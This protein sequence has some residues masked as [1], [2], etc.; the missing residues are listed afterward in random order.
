M[1]NFITG[2]SG[3]EHEHRAALAAVLG[4]EKAEFFFSRLIH[5][6]FTEA[7][8]AFFASV[9]FNC[10]RVPFNY[11]HFMD[12]DNP[13]VIKQSGFDVLDRIV[14][15]CAKH[16]IYVVLDL[17]AVPGGQNQDWHSDSGISRAL[18]WEFRDFQTRMIQ[19]WVAI[20]KHYAGN[21]VIAGYNPLNEPADPE[22][23]RLIEW[24]VRAEKAIREVD[25]EHIL[26]IDGNTYAMDFSHF[27][28]DKP[29]PNAVYSCHDYSMMGFPG[30]EQ[31]AGTDAQKAK[32]RSSFERKVHFMKEAGTPIWNGEFGP[33]YADPHVDKDAA[34]INEHRIELLRE[35]LRLYQEAGGVSWS[36]WTYKDIGYQGMVSVRRDS[37]YMRLIQPFVE[38]K[39]RLGV[40]FWGVVD[41]GAVEKDVYAP[42]INKLKEMVPE[43]LQKRKYPPVWSFDR[44]VERVVRECLLSEYLGWEMAE[45]FEGKTEAELEEL[46][47]SFRLENCMERSQLNEV[48]RRD[49]AISRKTE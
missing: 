10:L 12:D 37:P 31:Y 33:V 17:H 20:A 21:P 29:L 35:Q 28:V 45:L 18:F 44:Q 7:D 16:N 22:H 47:A 32:L 42:F 25:P 39:Q 48:L 5:H 36:I 13:D 46:A 43:H 4:K 19:L 15:L 41:K 6:F 27:P 23:T 11:R 30:M 1:E 9:G 40:D 49:A 24:Y 38:K 2:Y 34:A 3:H 8:A 26:F 14:S